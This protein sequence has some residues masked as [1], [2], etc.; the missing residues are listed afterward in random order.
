M[1]VGADQLGLGEAVL[2]IANQL[3][4]VISEQIDATPCLLEATRIAPSGCLSDRK[5][6]FLIRSTGPVLGGCHPQHVDGFLVEASARIKSASIDRLGDTVTPGQAA[7]HLG[8]AMRRGIIF[9]CQTDDCFEHA[10][11]I[12]GAAGQTPRRGGS[13]RAPPR[14]VSIRRHRVRRWRRSRRRRKGRW[15]ATLTQPGIRSPGELEQ[16]M[17]LDVL[18]VCRP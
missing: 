9:R 14:S 7:A 4:R 12:A 16:V 18:R 2:K 11:E 6:D 3:V 1:S 5:A 10:M 13:A 15:V 8:G 17:Q